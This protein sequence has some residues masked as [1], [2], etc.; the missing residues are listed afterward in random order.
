MYNVILVRHGEIHL[1]GDNRPYFENSLLKLIR[2]AVKKFGATVEKG[3]ERYFVRGVASEDFNAAIEALTKVFGIHSV[4][5]AIEVEK[6]LDSITE[7][8]AKLCS[9][10]L[11]NGNRLTFKVDSKRQDKR[12]PL[13]SMAL[14]AEL[15]GRMLEKFENL[16]V[17]VHTPDFK[18]FVEIRESAYVYTENIPGTGGM[19]VGTSGKGML[20][21]SGGIDSPVAGYMMAKR[22]VQLESVH[23]HSFP[24]TSERAKQKVIDLAKIVAQY[25]GPIKIHMVHFTD[26]QMTIHEKCPEDQLTLLMRVFMMKIAER[27][28][29][30]QKCQCLITGESLGQVASQTMASLG[31]TNSAVN[32]P[33][34]RPC[35]GMDKTEI[36][37]IANKIDTYET[38]IQP[39]ED[40]CTVFVPKHPVTHPKLEKIMQ[41]FEHLDHEALIKDALEK[42]EVIEVYPD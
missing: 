4:S 8:A 36:M 38:S 25:A 16:S 40:C 18:V 1:K 23:Y 30:Q 14:S 39:Y 11:S 7:C 35:I 22:G 2:A 19:P 10:K 6:D 3:R 24:Y 17:D 20:L 32:I 33:V 13:S 34:F 31:V 37:D 42:T 28:A 12:F 29:L 27:I 5:P 26:I 41:S 9:E 21:L 15:G